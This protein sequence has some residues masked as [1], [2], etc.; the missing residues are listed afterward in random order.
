MLV[1]KDKDALREVIKKALP[2]VEWLAQ[3]YNR[4]LDAS[5]KKHL[6][7]EALNFIARFQNEIERSHYISYLARLVSV[8]EVTIEK[9][10]NSSKINRRTQEEST[11]EAKTTTEERFIACLLNCSDQLPKIALPEIE[12]EDSSLLTIYKQ[13]QSCYNTSQAV[14]Q[15]IGKIK[16]KLSR[17]LRERL[18]AVSLE[19][20]EKFA[21]DKEASLEEFQQI[22]S[23]LMQREKEQIK[24]NF[25]KA[26][27]QAETSGDIAK[28]REL[29]KN[30][31]E[32]LK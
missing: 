22:K 29:M 27:A 4:P 25:A 26:I 30:L 24:S 7:R 11:K 13:L 16:G 20:D 12:L 8:A 14:N 28:V 18:D 19:W 17:E 3:A 15:E 23:H 32:S 6:V 10:L 31:Q 1:K 21:Q 9:V 2:P 5:Q